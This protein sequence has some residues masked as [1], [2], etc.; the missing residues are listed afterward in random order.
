MTTKE[1]LSE[2]YK[3]DQRIDCKLEQLSTLKAISTKISMSYGSDCG[4]QVRKRSTMENAIV[5]LID[6]ENEID[7]DI[8]ELIDL[9]KAVV[10]TF[11]AIEDHEQRLLLELRY[12]SYKTWEDIAQL[13]GYSYRQIHRIHRQAL[14]SIR[15]YK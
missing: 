11:K 3:L 15:V 1:Y 5:K 4:R 9:K 2:A 8:D 10:S 6:L 14:K 12:L 7:S 13:M